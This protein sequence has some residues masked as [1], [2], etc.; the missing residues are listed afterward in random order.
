MLNRPRKIMPLRDVQLYF[1]FM[2]SRMDNQRLYEW[3]TR[4]GLYETIDILGKNNESVQ[5]IE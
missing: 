4:M 1:W 3:Y 2:D 5:G